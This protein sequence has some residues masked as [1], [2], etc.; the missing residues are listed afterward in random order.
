ME[1][2][3]QDLEAVGPPLTRCTIRQASLSAAV[4]RLRE[5]S[6]VYLGPGRAPRR[7]R[8]L[9]TERYPEPVEV[10][11]DE[12]PHPVLRFVHGLDHL[13]PRSEPSG[14]CG[15]VLGVHIEIDLPALCGRRPPPGV[16][17][18][19][20][21]AEGE[22]RPVGVAVAGVDGQHREAEVRVP[23]GGC[24]NIGHVDHG[25]YSASHEPPPRHSRSRASARRS[26][27]ERTGRMRRGV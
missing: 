27:L 12:S 9:L 26:C 4:S 25:Y 23:G 3:G 20:P 19:P 10:P 6:P 16:Q 11:D 1:Q 15:D 21:L 8:D 18:D 5:P 14:E 7:A 17:H 24:A 2:G 22:H 13:D